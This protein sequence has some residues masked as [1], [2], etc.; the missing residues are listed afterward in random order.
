MKRL[1]SSIA[2]SGATAFGL[3]TAC[4]ST[5][6]PPAT[7]EPEARAD[8][9]E[10]S[11]QVD[12]GVDAGAAVCAPTP[13]AGS[14]RF[15]PSRAWHQDKCTAAQVAGYVRSCLESSSDVCAEYAKQNPAC[16]ACAETDEKAAEWGAIV[17][18]ANGSYFEE[19]FAGCVANALGDR[20]KDG[21]GGSQAQFE[22]CRRE[23]CRGCLPIETQDDY[24]DFASCGAK[25]DITKVCARELAQIG[26]KCVG[27]IDPAPDDPIMPCLGEGLDSTEYFRQYVALFCSAAPAGDAG[28]AST[29]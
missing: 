19:N 5:E 21:C 1:L 13:F 10:A 6:S 11:T 17:I 28:D 15:V 8:T 24:D 18:F 23:A 3:V 4:S 16:F 20:S 29:D 25:K 22:E 12:T 2:L 9:E 27:H 7:I 26:V 14:A